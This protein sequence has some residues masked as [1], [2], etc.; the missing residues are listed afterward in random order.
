[1]QAHPCASVAVNKAAAP[2]DPDDCHGPVKA[3]ASY[4]GAAVPQLA[5]PFDNG[6]V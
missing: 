3:Q 6:A 4:V 1:M 2:A 5:R